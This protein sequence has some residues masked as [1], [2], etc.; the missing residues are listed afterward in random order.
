[1]TDKSAIGKHEP[2]EAGK[3]TVLNSVDDFEES[4]EAAT[5]DPPAFPA[6]VYA[7]TNPKGI[8][9][10]ARLQQLSSVTNGNVVIDG[11]FFANLPQNIQQ[12]SLQQQE[13]AQ[14][15]QG[16]KETKGEDVGKDS[17]RKGA[18][19]GA[20]GMVSEVGSHAQVDIPPSSKAST[21]AEQGNLATFPTGN[22]R[23]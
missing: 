20:I 6:N 14:N 12:Q 8:T 9:N 22:S 18:Q 1:M 2:H 19:G 11:V 23:H 13:D 4:N 7:A 17:R 21:G 16:G 15:G 3:K 5:S 10:P